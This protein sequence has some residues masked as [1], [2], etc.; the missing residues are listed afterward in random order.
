MAPK[1]S[2]RSR[3][4]A[5]EEV[6]TLTYFGMACL[7]CDNAAVHALHL[8]AGIFG[9]GTSIALALAHSGLQWKVI[10]PVQ[11]LPCLPQ[12]VDRFHLACLLSKPQVEFPD[13]WPSLKVC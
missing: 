7:H 8:R 5:E 11:C 12:F 4:E 9:K 3:P 10:L 13:D 6:Y 2:K 1:R